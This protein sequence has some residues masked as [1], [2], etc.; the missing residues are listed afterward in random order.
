MQKQSN[1]CGSGIVL[2]AAIFASAIPPVTLAAQTPHTQQGNVRRVSADYRPLAEQLLPG[3]RIVEF[4]V[5]TPDDRVLANPPLTR[6]EALLLAVSEAEQVVM[7]EVQTADNRL[8]DK[9]R[10]IATRL[11]CKVVEVM[12][13]QH[14]PTL[15][16]GANIS[17]QVVGGEVQIN[18]VL[19]RI[20]S[21]A[22]YKVGLRY[23]AFLKTR[24]EP[25]GDLTNRIYGPQPRLVERD[26]L[27]AFPGDDKDKLA[28]LTLTDV[29]RAAAKPR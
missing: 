23:L 28:G 26:Q 24:E 15:G 7:V 4:L 17:F 27:K 18:G 9:G 16:P 25:A 19:V 11:S 10:L 2:F 8:I 22:E 20:R 3:D 5:D 12:K 14:L 21:Q 13:P 29:R 1:P 6:Q